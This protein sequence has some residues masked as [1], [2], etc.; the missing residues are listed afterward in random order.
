[1]D[2]YSKSPVQ[3]HPEGR[4]E[5]YTATRYECNKFRRV[6]QQ[7]NGI[8]SVNLSLPPYR[9]PEDCQPGVRPHSR[10]FVPTVGSDPQTRSVRNVTH[11]DRT[12]RDLPWI[13]RSVQ[14][15]PGRLRCSPS[16]GPR[17]GTM[18]PKEE[19]PVRPIRHQLSN[20][21]PTV[22]LAT[23]SPRVSILDPRWHFS[24]A[25]RLRTC[26][27]DLRWPHGRPPMNPE[28][29]RSAAP[30]TKRPIVSGRH[31]KRSAL[32]THGDARVS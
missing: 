14:G 20:L 11:G 26:C 3:F 17:V 16:V 1:M 19:T 28:R 15:D 10:G 6:P 18:H 25:R 4:A 9:G 5:N 27:L 22:L 7:F 21:S 8:R 30:G 2:I 31:W 32:S 13:P 12:L 23:S 24:A 29:Q